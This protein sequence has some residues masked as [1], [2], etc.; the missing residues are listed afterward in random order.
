MFGLEII[1]GI[2]I[3]IILSVVNVMV[4]N[5]NSYVYYGPLISI[6]GISNPLLV[7]GILVNIGINQVLEFV[8]WDNS[9]LLTV[10]PLIQSVI[11]TKTIGQDRS[12]YICNKIVGFILAI[13]I[14]YGLNLLG[15]L[16]ILKINLVI[17]PIGFMI[18]GLLLWVVYKN[19]TDK[20]LASVAVLGSIGLALIVILLGYKD[21]NI[22][23]SIS[24]ALFSIGG[25][26]EALTNKTAYFKSL[27][28][29][30]V[31]NRTSRGKKTPKVV[32]KQGKNNKKELKNTLHNK[33]I[34]IIQVNRLI[35]IITGFIGSFFIAL[36]SSS[37]FT[38]LNTT[39][40][41]R[42]E[43]YESTDKL[44]Q[45][46]L[47]K[48]ISEGLS[49]VL[50]AFLIGERDASATYI[51]PLITATAISPALILFILL[52]SIIIGYILY[53]PLSNLVQSNDS[54]DNNGGG[55]FK[56][57]LLKGLIPQIIILFAP[58]ALMG[59]S[60]LI[61]LSLLIWSFIFNRLITNS[62]LDRSFSTSVLTFIPIIGMMFI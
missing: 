41:R 18:G 30:S 29:N 40:N 6:L 27:N 33:V 11:T 7:L 48:G 26:L 42:G 60:I 10:D 20:V 47:S 3:G 49:L 37:L 25:T 1:G 55:A 59:G 31:R 8:R 36:N 56:S 35:S 15:A 45:Y 9:E 17:V 19:S 4:P 43:I 32:S 14:G 13:G 39:N 2:G 52:V 46:I 38:Y 44:E 58:Y 61:P 51:N 62:G 28:I 12:K 34:N 50:S 23:F 5:I 53:K 21:G 57:N 24:T 54:N 22:I 16:S